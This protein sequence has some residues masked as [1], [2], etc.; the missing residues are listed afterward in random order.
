MENGSKKAAKKLSVIIAT[1]NRPKAAYNLAVKIRQVQ[2]DVQII[3]VDQMNTAQ[4]EQTKLAT[5]DIE[6]INLYNP[7]LTQARNA[8]LSKAIGDIVL[9][10]DDDV[11]ITKDTLN[12][13]LK[14]YTDPKVVGVAGRVINDDETVPQIS[15]VETGKT[16]LLKTFFLQQFWSTKEQ[17]VDF[18]Y[19]CN[20]SY[21]TFT[22]RKIGGFDSFFSRIFDEIDMGLR[23][24]KEGNMLFVP[25]TLVYH[26]KA[27]SGGIR[28][29]E[30]QKKQELIF[31]NYGYIIRKHVQFPFSL[32]TLILRTITALKHGLRPAVGLYRGFLSV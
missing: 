17:R 5:N 27:K 1:Y 18:P 23:M 11:E 2:N 14:A 9:Y 7:H 21:R 19:G 25:S 32:I 6:Y 16:N 13:H 29:D 30:E 22:L 3:I 4:C 24:N 26:H 10:L 12:G 28:H 20:M 31:K 15:N 8:G